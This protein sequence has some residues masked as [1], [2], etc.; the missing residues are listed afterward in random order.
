MARKSAVGKTIRCSADEIKPTTPEH[1]AKLLALMDTEPDT[2]DIAEVEIKTAARVLRDAE[3]RLVKGRQSPIRTAI[4]AELDR[5]E[6]T[7][8]KLWKKARVLCGTLPQSAVY[9]YLRGH[10]EIGLPYAEAM[11]QVVGLVVK[12]GVTPRNGQNRTLM[13]DEGDWP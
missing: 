5:R 11:M 10:R 3:G 2:S 1:L 8:Y 13:A 9:E 4:L 6:M 7:R 12:R